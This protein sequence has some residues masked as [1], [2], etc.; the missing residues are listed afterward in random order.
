MSQAA[1]RPL[2][3]QQRCQH[4]SLIWKGAVD[5]LG[6]R[7]AGEHNLA[8]SGHLH[9]SEPKSACHLLRI[10]TEHTPGAGGGAE[11]AHKLTGQEFL[12]RAPAGAGDCGSHT[13][14]HL[15]GHRRGNEELAARDAAGRFRHRQRCS[16]A[17]HTS[18]PDL[19]SN[20]VVI[21]RVH[22]CAIGEGGIWRRDLYCQ[23][24][25]GAF[26]LAAEPTHDGHHLAAAVAECRRRDRTAEGV[27]NHP[28]DVCDDVVRQ[29]V[30]RQ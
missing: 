2:L 5:R 13:R 11:I 7:I 8:R 28:F 3:A 9:Q 4:P 21:K 22:Q 16:E 17:D 29:S 19:R 30:E 20:R 24:D 27:E 10:K 15:A 23:P 18:V 14:R 6:R 26:R 12:A 25:D 1:P